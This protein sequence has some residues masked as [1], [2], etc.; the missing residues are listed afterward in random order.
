MPWTLVPVDYENYF[1][2]TK[3]PPLTQRAIEAQACIAVVDFDKDPGTRA[4]DR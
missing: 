4:A 3:L 2:T 1:S